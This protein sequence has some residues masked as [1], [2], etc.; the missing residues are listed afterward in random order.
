MTDS[1]PP[2]E[3]GED[4]YHV[5]ASTSLSPEG[6]HVL[7]HGDMFVLVDH[8]GDIQ[9]ASAGEQGVYYGGTRFVSRLRLRLDR[10]R[11]LLL[12]SSVAEDNL[13]LQVDM[14]NPDLPDR[15][16]HASVPYGTVHLARSKFLQE[17]TYF[18]RVLLSNYGAQ[19]VDVELSLDF[20]ADFVDIF[21]VRGTRR[22]RRGSQ[23]RAELGESEVALLY[24]GLDGFARRARFEF[25]PKPD[26]LQSGLAVFNVH[27]E[28]KESRE[29][30]LWI[31]CQVTPRHA[32]PGRVQLVPFEAALNHSSK[33]LRSLEA[34]NCEIYTSN[35]QFN[36]WLNRSRSDLRMLV[37]DTPQGPYPYAG[38]PWFSTPFGRD[39][40]WTALQ[41]LWVQPQIAAG[42]LR[43]L[44][45]YQ[46]TELDPA[47]DAQPGKILHEM[48]AG[49]MAALREI[50]FGRYYGSI[51]S[52][53]L[54][55]MLAARYYEAT[56]DRALIESIWPN[57]LS[58]VGWL[59]K[60]GDA[61]GDGFIEYGRQ[62]KDGLV[63][64]GWKDSN[65][66]VFHR[67]GSAA[68]GPIALAEVQGYAYAALRGMAGL[69]LA[70][71]EPDLRARWDA[72]AERL[73]E[74]FDHSFWCGDLATYA[75]A[76]D[77][78]KLPCRVR[79]SNAGHCLYTGIAL[80]TR[81]AAIAQQLTAPDMFSGWG[82]RT[83]ASSEQRYNP[84]SYHNGSIWPHDNAIVASGL[85]ACGHKELAA[86][87][88]GSLF[89]ATLFMNLHRLPELFCGFTRQAGQGPT[90]YPVA[91]SPQAWASGAVFMLL[92]AVIGLEVDAVERRVVLRHAFLPPF[93]EE[94]KI[95]DLRVGE[96][97]VDLRLIRHRDDVGVTVTRK[98]GNV[99][100]VGVQ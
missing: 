89:D 87:V 28:S 74:R 57:L 63:Q 13:L 30:Y 26:R 59:E 9:A 45:T 69:A 54:Y 77:D 38:V 43:F 60:Y 11:P 96:A 35:E 83:L 2:S 5:V 94:V 27:L 33:T 21:E 90:Q 58:A 80:P 79:T 3:Q 20:A 50:P 29:I 31:E 85:A 73:R 16:E 67:D 56:A 72:S 37:T 84:M 12:S 17:G 91:C 75:L 6:T 46:A 100:V 52:T 48:R 18:E 76:L 95:R 61:D 68:S 78:K 47:S 14:T 40:L 99:D 15:P 70:L 55:L 10:H 71:G 39:G 24:Y 32:I 1:I 98:V 82:I 62:S 42:V 25:A 81:V 23:Q 34:S 92:Q 36:D 22:E 4:R 19:A 97:S 86:R 88:L 44:S 49:E 66:S 53:P 93:L 41:V 7:K 64:Q 65:D 51:D 8:F